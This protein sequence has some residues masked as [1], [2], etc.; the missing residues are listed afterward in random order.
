MLST[1]IRDVEGGASDIASSSSYLPYAVH[2]LGTLLNPFVIAN[3]LETTAYGIPQ[4]C[5]SVN[6]ILAVGSHWEHAV[7]DFVAS[8]SGDIEAV[9]DALRLHI[10]A[11]PSEESTLTSNEFLRSSRFNNFLGILGICGHQAHSSC[12]P[13]TRILHRSTDGG[14]FEKYVILSSSK[15]GNNGDFVD[16]AAEHIVEG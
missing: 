12:A 4:V 5:L 10:A 14:L 2:K 8:W 11:T 9:V 3:R 6:S 13:G 15:Q 1:N 16:V 7:A